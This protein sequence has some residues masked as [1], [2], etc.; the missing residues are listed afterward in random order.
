MSW[1]N[2]VF[3]LVDGH[4]PAKGGRRI[5]PSLE[6]LCGRGNPSLK[7]AQLMAMVLFVLGL[8]PLSPRFRHCKNVILFSYPFHQP[9]KGRKLS[10]WATS[11][12]HS[13]NQGN[14]MEKAKTYLIWVTVS[15][16]FCALKLRLPDFTQSEVQRPPWHSDFGRCTR[17][18]SQRR[19]IRRITHANACRPPNAPR[20]HPQN[21]PHKQENISTDN[22]VGL[23]SRIVDAILGGSM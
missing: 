13:D 6:N 12:G 14:V 22:G 20:A 1:R 18:H 11:L 16:K 10:Q 17:R 8:L 4:W 2:A 23:R 21:S 7:H 15:G 19:Q 9:N 5:F 3:F